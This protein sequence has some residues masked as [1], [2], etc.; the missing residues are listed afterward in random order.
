[1]TWRE[2]EDKTRQAM[3]VASFFALSRFCRVASDRFAGINASLVQ[4]LSEG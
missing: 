1:M 2:G 3:L 4:F